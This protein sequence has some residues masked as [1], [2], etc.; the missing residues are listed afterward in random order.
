[1]GILTGALWIV[2]PVEKMTNSL[3][4]KLTFLPIFFYRLL[5]WQIIMIL[6]NSFSCFAFVGVAFSN[7][8]VLFLFIQDRLI[9]EPINHALLSLIFPVFKLP[10]SQVDD[11]FSLKIFFWLICPLAPETWQ[12]ASVNC[13]QPLR[14]LW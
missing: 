9:V 10:S 11:S 14:P 8:I 13:C 6:L 1:M 2:A 3:I 7:W 12:S 4:G 5:V